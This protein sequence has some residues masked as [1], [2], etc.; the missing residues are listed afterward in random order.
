MI[1]VFGIDPAPAKGLS[2][3]SIETGFQQVALSESVEFMDSLS[4]RKN[5]LV[6]WDSPLTGPSH[7]YESGERLVSGDLTQRSIE[8]F[9]SRGLHGFKTPRG[10][11]VRGYAGCPHWTVSQY[12]L[13]LP[14][15]SSRFQEE[16]NLPFELITSDAQ[17][18]G[19]RPAIIEVHPAVALWLWLRD[20]HEIKN[21]MYKKD[22]AIREQVWKSLCE[23]DAFSSCFGVTGPPETENDDQLDALI[24]FVLGTLWIRKDSEVVLLG[25]GQ[26][27]CLLLPRSSGLVESWRVFGG[28]V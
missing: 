2:V 24:A 3:F 28:S 13:G 4:A 25:N 23:I 20:V 6:C 21:W 18:V 10:I 17:P 5:L 11:S 27:G 26:S 12:L 8:Q 22:P 15:I 19:E 16:K 9:F 14:V 1:T 7:G